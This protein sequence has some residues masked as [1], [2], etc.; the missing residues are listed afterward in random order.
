M[1]LIRLLCWRPYE[2]IDLVMI[3]C[4]RYEGQ[5]A[6]EGT[7]GVFSSVKM[8]ILNCHLSG[9]YKTTEGLLAGRQAL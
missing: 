7:E 8:N 2:F 9:V 4:I 5:W 3:P 6:S 1:P